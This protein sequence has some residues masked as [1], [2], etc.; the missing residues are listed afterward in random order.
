MSKQDRVLKIIF[1]GSP[2]FACPSLQALITSGHDIIHV[3]TQPPRAAGRG[4]AEKKTPVAGLALLHDI[5]VSWPTSLSSQDEIDR[6]AAFEAD[7]FVVVAY[8]L[9]LPKAILNLPKLGCVNGHASL[10]PRWRGAAPIQRA[11]AAGD[12]ITGTAAMMMEEGLDT[13]PVIHHATTDIYPHDTAATLHDRL[14]DM[15]ADT[16]IAAIAMLAGGT[17]KPVPQSQ[18]GVRYAAKIQ[19][20]EARLDLSQEA[21]RLT[22]LIH[23]LSPFPGCFIE[24]KSDKRLKFLQARHEAQTHNAPIGTYLGRSPQSAEAEE[25][26][27]IACGNGSI[28]AITSLQPAGKKPMSASDFLRG[29]ALDEGHDM[30]GQL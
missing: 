27:M 3:L 1:M 21:R 14:A 2:D 28:L 30:A 19:K 7:L 13:G 22:Y 5:S 8:G 25:A 16:L 9:I 4:M 6:L 12:S 10:L 20:S 26:I 23:A 11:I 24:T 18:D 17:A 15:T 29:R